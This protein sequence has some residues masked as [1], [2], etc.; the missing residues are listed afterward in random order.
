MTSKRT[1]L[2]ISVSFAAFVLTWTC[3]AIAVWAAGH[4]DVENYIY[5]K[6]QVNFIV[7]MLVL[8]LAGFFFG[9]WARRSAPW[10]GGA[11]SL[12]NACSLIILVLVP[13]A[14]L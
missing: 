9:M 6:L 12:L 1:R 10:A 13:K 5:G 8:S 7:P 4:P 11:A 3:L 2:L 14:V